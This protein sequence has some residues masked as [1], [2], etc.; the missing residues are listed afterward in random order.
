MEPT[1]FGLIFNY[2]IQMM[3][4]FAIAVGV[5]TVT[6]LRTTDVMSAW[7][8]T[9]GVRLAICVVLFWV[10]SA[11]LVIVP[12]IATILGSLG[13]AADQSAAGIALALAGFILTGRG[14]STEL[15]ADQ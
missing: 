14:D 5:Y 15:S 2:G 10:I 12:N 4:A 3:L 6:V 11:G 7:Y 9:N 1:N 13:F 8:R